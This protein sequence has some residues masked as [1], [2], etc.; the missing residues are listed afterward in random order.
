MD[1]RH[2]DR[3]SQR[4]ACKLGLNGR[5]HLGLVLNVSTRGLFIQTRAKA[6][7]EPNVVVSVELCPPRSEQVLTLEALLARQYWVPDQLLSLARGGMGLLIRSVDDAW[8]Q[9]LAEL[10]AKELVPAEA[11][12]AK[13][14]RSEGS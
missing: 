4:I 14:E 7:S 2:E 6:P 8:Y 13:S 3:F 9:L 5:I 11:I 1:R 12:S 10:E